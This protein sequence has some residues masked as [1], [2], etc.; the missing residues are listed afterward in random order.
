MLLRDRILGFLKK[1]NKTSA[2]FAEEIGVQPSG[3][4]H[5]LSGRNN[6]SLDFIIKMLE[7]YP[8]LSSEWLLF[9]RGP[10]Y[11][12]QYEGSLFDELITDG[13][14]M[15][16]DREN[17]K[18]SNEQELQLIDNQVDINVPEKNEKETLHKKIIRIIWFYENNTFEEFLPGKG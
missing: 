9:G 10:M 12:D 6:P 1:E 17:Q 14:N 5:I 8:Y 4:S 13:D 3:I 7:K 15:S 16:I 18:E 11:K 2:Q